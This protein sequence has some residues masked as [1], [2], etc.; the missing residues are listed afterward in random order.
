MDRRVQ[1]VLLMVL[2]AASEVYTVINYLNRKTDFST[3]VICS[4]LLG[5]LLFG[6][7]AALIRERDK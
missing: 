2:L 4:G 5:F 3:L 6:Q 7:I 1:R